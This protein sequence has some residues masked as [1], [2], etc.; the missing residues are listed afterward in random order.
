MSTVTLFTYSNS[1]AQLTVGIKDTATEFRIYLSV[2][3]HALNYFIDISREYRWLSN[4]APVSI[5][6]E[7][8]IYPTVE[9]AYQAAKT[10]SDREA[11]LIQACRTPG[12]AKRM[13]RRLTIRPDWDQIKRSVMLELL[14]L[15]FRDHPYKG[16]LTATDGTI[17]IEGNYWG[18]VYWGMFRGKGQNV[19]GQLLTQVRSELLQ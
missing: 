2:R 19:L 1:E 12:D 4:F 6:Y 5:A 10:L 13:G 16:L 7:G 9:H 11:A 14:R 15:K 18:D 8:N 17:M 3:D